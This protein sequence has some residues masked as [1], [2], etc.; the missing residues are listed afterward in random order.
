MGFRSNCTPRRGFETRLLN[1]DLLRLMKQRAL[2]RSTCHWKRYGRTSIGSRIGATRALSR[3]NANWRQPSA[4][5]STNISPMRSSVAK[6][7][8]PLSGEGQCRRRST[9]FHRERNKQCISAA[10]RGGGTLRK[11]IQVQSRRRGQSKPANCP[12][13]E[14]RQVAKRE[15]VRQIEQGVP[16]RQARVHSTG[17]IASFQRSC[18]QPG[19]G[20]A[21]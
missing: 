17:R 20:I 7:M 6:S 4:Q 9:A 14:Q 12:T 18:A 19:F 5:V 10:I 8:R 11:N 16:A 2:R 1:E 3:L 21:V 15:I 13:P